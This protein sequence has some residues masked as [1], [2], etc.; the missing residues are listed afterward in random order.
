MLVDYFFMAELKVGV[1]VLL[2]EVCSHF[3]TYWFRC[4]QRAARSLLPNG[5][6]TLFQTLQMGRMRFRRM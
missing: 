5:N 3:H 6:P 2:C 4:S 1:S